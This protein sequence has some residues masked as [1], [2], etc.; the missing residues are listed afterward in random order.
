[1]VEV[2]SVTAVSKT[3]DVQPWPVPGGRGGGTGLS[4]LTKSW[5]EYSLLTLFFS[6]SLRLFFGCIAHSLIS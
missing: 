6:L 5:L 3:R 2:G 1:M 4:S